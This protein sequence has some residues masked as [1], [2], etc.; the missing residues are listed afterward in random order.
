MKKKKIM[1]VPHINYVT[2]NSLSTTK[3]NHLALA[4]YASAPC[5][6]AT[7]KANAIRFTVEKANQ[8]LQ[9]N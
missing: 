6:K 9:S 8:H 7:N 4:T 3:L 5:T 1:T 2:L